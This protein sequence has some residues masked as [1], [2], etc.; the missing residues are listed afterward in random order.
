MKKIRQTTINNIKEF[1]DKEPYI[2]KLMR[3][4]LINITALAR[5]IIKVKK[6][7]MTLDAVVSAIRRYDFKGTKIIY[8][9]ALNLIHQ[10]RSI[11]VKNKL[12]SISLIKDSDIQ[13]LLPLLFSMIRYTQGDILRIVQADESIRIFINEKNF[14]KVLKIF[15][16][17]K[18]ICIDRN[19]AEI[20]IH[21]HPEAKNIIGIAS[22]ITNEFALNDI[23]ILDSMS[24]F[25]E[26]MW[27][28]DEKDASKAYDV[29]FRLCK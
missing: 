12:A 29:I 13:R 4:K 18:I 24:S 25:P 10:T 22:I 16:E 19:L 27:F 1:L 17:D 8:D 14:E 28:V 26:S 20:N 3:I 7:D 21:L 11:S 5:Y 2:R 9:K 6:L 15:P 23:N